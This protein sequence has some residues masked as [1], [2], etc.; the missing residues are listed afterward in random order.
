ML[1][2]R[3]HSPLVINSRHVVSSYSILKRLLTPYL[4]YFYELKEFLY[5]DTGL[6][7]L[8]VGLSYENMVDIVLL[9]EG[10]YTGERRRAFIEC[11]SGVL[12]DKVNLHYNYIDAYDYDYY[13]Y[14][15]SAIQSATYILPDGDTYF[16]YGDAVGSVENEIRDVIES[17][18][19]DVL[20]ML[21]TDILSY[22]DILGNMSLE[23]ERADELVDDYLNNDEDEDDGYG[24]D[25]ED[26][27]EDDEIRL[28][29]DRDLAV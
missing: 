21:P 16:D 10:L 3:D 26:M 7:E 5:D 8:F 27:S 22:Y 13:I 11:V 18:I 28:M 4:I 15:D 29:F 6:C 20:D 12:N 2:L 1:Y 25:E 9:I 24:D 23:I 14:V 17:S 19:K